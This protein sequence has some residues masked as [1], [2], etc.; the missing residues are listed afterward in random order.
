MRKTLFIFS[1]ILNFTLSY[2]ITG[3][4]SYVI[5]AS[6][7][8]TQHSIQST[9]SPKKTEILQFTSSGHVLGFHKNGV[10]V[11][12]GSHIL[13]ER[14]VDT[15]GVSPQAYHLPTKNGRDESLG[16]VSY[17]NL[18]DGI[19]LTYDKPSEGVLRS[20]FQVAPGAN[21]DNIGLYYNV[22]ACIDPAGN[23]VFT[24]KTGTMT[25]SAPIAWQE[26][27]GKNQSVEV[28]FHCDTSR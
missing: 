8:A 10:Y 4:N 11:A 3:N 1:L 25:A 22:P 15:K 16:S 9:I 17:S 14:F 23:L 18:W 27:R 2:N 28:A 13:W 24:F 12:T 7:W 6:A 5:T 26:I 20:T 21:P 19:S